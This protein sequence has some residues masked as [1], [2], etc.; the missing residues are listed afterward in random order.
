[1]NA[2]VAIAAFAVSIAV[3]WLLLRTSVGARLVAVPTEERWHE[4][5]TPTFGGVGIYAGLAAGVLVALA[6][7]IIEWSSELGG[8]LAG[9]TIVF[10][11]G[12]IDDIRHLSPLAKLAAQVT[13]AVIVI[14]SGL[15]VEIVGSSATTLSRGPSGSSGSWASR[16]RS[17][18]S[19]TWTGSPRRSRSWRA[20]TSRSTR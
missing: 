5:P 7:G 3:L 11:A 15:N 6:T 12:L 1:V 8:V 4:Q 14:A 17:T 20:R 19:T 2:I 9:V 10:V 16:T 13:A 18:S